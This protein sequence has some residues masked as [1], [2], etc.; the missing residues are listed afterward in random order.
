MKTILYTFGVILMI[1]FLWSLFFTPKQPNCREGDT[2]QA[3]ALR[4]QVCENGE[5]V[6]YETSEK[7]RAVYAKAELAKY[8]ARLKEKEKFCGVGNVDEDFGS[9]WGY[10][11]SPLPCKD[12]S[13]VPD[14]N[15]K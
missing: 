4:K 15:L 5:R 1:Y 10:S 3:D 12:Y 7:E 13:K 11:Q 2:Y 8:K 14:E 9:A 6:T